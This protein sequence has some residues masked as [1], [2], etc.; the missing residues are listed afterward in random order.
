MRLKS[1]LDI[2]INGILLPLRSRPVPKY[3]IG[4]EGEWEQRVLLQYYS[5]VC[6]SKNQMLLHFSKK[7]TSKMLYIGQSRNFS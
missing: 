5:T 3:A 7:T 4:S 1:Y 2:G 6:I